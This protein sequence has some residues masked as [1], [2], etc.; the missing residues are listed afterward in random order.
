MKSLAF[1]LLALLLIG[2]GCASDTDSAATSADAASDDP[3]QWVTYEGKDGPGTGK[4]IVLVSGDEEYRSEEV[5]P[6]LAQI[7][8][9]R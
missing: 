8:A 6:E 7:L 1:S 5:L 9:E 2:F 3:P 4:Q